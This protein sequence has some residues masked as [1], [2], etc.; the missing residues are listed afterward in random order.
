MRAGIADRVRC[1]VQVWNWNN[2]KDHIGSRRQTLKEFFIAP[3]FSVRHLTQNIETFE[4]HVREDVASILL[5]QV[6]LLEKIMSLKRAII[7]SGE[8]VNLSSYRLLLFLLDSPSI[9]SKAF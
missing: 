8:V 7:S 3:A 6:D 1:L 2:L 5:R 9:D 4:R